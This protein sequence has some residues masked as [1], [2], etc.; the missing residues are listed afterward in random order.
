MALQKSW[1][2]QGM[3]FPESYWVIARLE[4]RKNM[5]D[6]EDPVLAIAPQGAPCE[7]KEIKEGTWVC[8]SFWGYQNKAVRDNDAENNKYIAV[9]SDNPVGMGWNQSQMCAVVHPNLGKPDDPN[10]NYWSTW[11][12]LDHS[13]GM[14]EQAYA[15]AK[16][17]PFFA[18]AE[19]V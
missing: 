2:Y 10:D 19:S 12:K 3:S 15:H 16:T 7:D 11:F 18:D 13:K 5:G 1:S 4:T 9:F 17:H 6:K 14:I 8:V